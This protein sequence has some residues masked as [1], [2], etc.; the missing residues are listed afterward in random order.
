MMAPLTA[1]GQTISICV[2]C[3]RT[4]GSKA[5]LKAH[6]KNSPK[7]VPFNCKTCNRSFGDQTALSQ[8]QDNSPAHQRPRTDSVTTSIA[9]VP[10]TN[11][12]SP[13]L[14]ATSNVR[15][16]IRNAQPSRHTTTKN[17]PRVDPTFDLPFAVLENRMQA[18]AI[19]D[20]ITNVAQPKIGR[21]NIPTRQTETRTFFTFPELHQR[22]AEAVA[23][24]ITSTWFNKGLK[25]RA[26]KDYDT[27]VTGKFTCDNN[28]CRKNGWSSGVVATRIRGYPGSGYKAIVYNQ[29]CKSCD[30]LG[31]LK[32]D[33]ESYVERIAY[34][35]KKWAGVPVE[36]PPFSGQSRG[37][38]DEERCEGCRAGNCRWANR[39]L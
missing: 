38:H 22:I 3:N 31:S 30:Q 37:P 5:A 11:C 8:H 7:H 13:V 4:F 35:L 29:R 20:L 39:S 21:T 23:P 10:V 24:A 32:M 16:T 18:L 2:S 6:E 17:T 28:G 12:V 19:P 25:A 15:S 26:D 1:T 14:P 9:S 36:P 27:N 34:R 33:E